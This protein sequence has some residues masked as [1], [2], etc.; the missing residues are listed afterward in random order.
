M[1]Y[2]V[3]D[4]V[5]IVKNWD[6]TNKS[7]VNSSGRMDRWLGKIM[8]I[9]ETHD[10]YYK[11]IDDSAENFGRGWS[12]F[13]D[14]IEGLATSFSKPDL[15]TGD[16]IQCRNG[17]IGIAIVDMNV[18]IFEKGHLSMSHF[19]TDLTHI[20]NH[21]FDIAAIRRPIGEL[22]C[23]FNAFECKL[24]ILIYERS[25]P[26]EMTFTEVCKLLGKEIKIIK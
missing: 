4:R 19:Q 17:G 24:G 5:R 13:A 21:A 8:T 6:K 18:I 20:F 25:E 16:V 7:R 23:D 15:K 22:A 1:K 26:E 10:G 11:M 14:M 3:G 9:K 2:K 12:W